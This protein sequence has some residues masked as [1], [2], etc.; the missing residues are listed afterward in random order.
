[1]QG[2]T[3]AVT[4]AVGFPRNSV[5]SSVPAPVLEG[6]YGKEACPFSLKQLRASE[7]AFPNLLYSVADSVGMPGPRASPLLH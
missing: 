2:K 4:V 6:W 1:M 5:Q 3:L 7:H